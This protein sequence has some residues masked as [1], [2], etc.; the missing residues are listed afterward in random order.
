MATKKKA[1]TTR[2]QRGPTAEAD[3]RTAAE[4][5]PGDSSE[6]VGTD[7]SVAGTDA[8]AERDREETL[9]TEEEI[10]LEDPAVTKKADRAIQKKKRAITEFEKQIAEF[11]EGLD[12]PLDD[13]TAA[14]MP[15]ADDINPGFTAMDVAGVKDWFR[16]FVKWL[17]NRGARVT[18]P[19]V[20]M[21]NQEN[22]SARTVTREVSQPAAAEMR[23]KPAPVFEA[24]IEWQYPDL[25]EGGRRPSV[26]KVSDDSPRARGN[27]RR[28]VAAAQ[29]KVA[30]WQAKQAPPVKVQLVQFT[31]I[32]A[33]RDLAQQALARRHEV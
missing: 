22:A 31:E 14:A 15:K 4:M 33:W 21:V 25:S 5:G 9:N 32:D 19:T 12:N 6:T 13:A 24:T 1:T 26:P 30:E 3:K 2:T 10:A 27:S 23:E 20:I 17:R 16:E 29:E 28:E 7:A 11:E 8:A 18:P